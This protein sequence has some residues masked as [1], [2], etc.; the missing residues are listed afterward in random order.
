L[1]ISSSPRWTNAALTSSVFLP[2]ILVPIYLPTRHSS[3]TTAPSSSG[4]RISTTSSRYARN[5][6]KK[7]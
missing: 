3:E 7:I 2:F 6:K 4:T 5:S 1:T